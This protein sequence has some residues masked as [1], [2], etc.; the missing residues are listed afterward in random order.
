MSIIEGMNDADLYRYAGWV[1]SKNYSSRWAKLEDDL[2]Q[3]AVIYV[4]ERRERFDETK[5]KLESWLRMMLRFGM[6]NEF[7]KKGAHREIVSNPRVGCAMDRFTDCA[8]MTN[9]SDLVD[10][11]PLYSFTLRVHNGD[12]KL[13]EKQHSVVCSVL[14]G[15]SCVNVRDLEGVSSQAVHDRL[16]K[17]KVKIRKQLEIESRDV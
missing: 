3:S 1:F 11:D 14:S 10:P 17:A 15:L 2:I 12:F 9:P 8:E 5:G 7:N 13:P 16:H 4:W 6:S